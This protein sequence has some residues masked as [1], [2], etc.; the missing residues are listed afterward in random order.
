MTHRLTINYKVAEMMFPDTSNEQ[1][2]TAL[3]HAA[4]RARSIN[5]QDEYERSLRNSL[6]PTREEFSIVGAHALA[7]FA[8][9]PEGL[10][11]AAR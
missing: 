7:R 2:R 1:Q 10:H 11:F 8:S 3:D 9:A 5:P 4:E 6:A